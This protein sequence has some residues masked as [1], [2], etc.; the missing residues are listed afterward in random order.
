[1]AACGDSSLPDR[2]LKLIVNQELIETGSAFE[3][4]FVLDL[5]SE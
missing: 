2:E 1:M 4:H 3:V 5:P